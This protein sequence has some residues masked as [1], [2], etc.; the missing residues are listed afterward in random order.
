MRDSPAALQGV[1]ILLIPFAKIAVIALAG[2]LWA[3][4]GVAPAVS[5]MPLGMMQEGAVASARTDDSVY[6][7]E[8]IERGAAEGDVLAQAAMRIQEGVMRFEESVDVTDLGLVRDQGI[9]AYSRFRDEYIDV[10]WAPTMRYFVDAEGKIVSYE[11]AYLC[12]RDEIAKYRTQLDAAITHGLTW[13]SE[14]MS[15]E[16]RALALHDYLNSV[17]KYDH[18]G[19]E[20]GTLTVPSQSAWGALVDGI[21]VCSGYAR[22]YQLLCRAVGIE[23]VYVVSEEMNHA[24]N[25]IKIDGAWYH[26]DTCWDD[27]EALAVSRDHFL[28]SDEAMAAGGYS[29]WDFEQVCPDLRFDGV[30]WGAAMRGPVGDEGVRGSGFDAAD[31]VKDGS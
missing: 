28:K 27:I 31:M 8:D 23:C 5:D 22:A 2:T 20:S 1:Y 19:Y 3:G 10:F 12:S 24:W 14:D 30:I 6:S 15:D 9:E 29:G 4:G 11:P 17:C 21:A 26:V 7:H 25:V 16:E 13:I 18:E